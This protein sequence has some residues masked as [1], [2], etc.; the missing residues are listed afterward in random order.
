MATKMALAALTFVA[1]GFVAWIWNRDK[2][3]GK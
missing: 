3:E 1:F 2:G